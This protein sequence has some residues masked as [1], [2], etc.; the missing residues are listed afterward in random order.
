M[1][2]DQQLGLVKVA[3]ILVICVRVDTPNSTVQTTASTSEDA[4]M[5]DDGDDADD[6]GA[7][8][9]DETN[10]QDLAEL[11]VHVNAL[12][13]K[14]LSIL[15]AFG[16][17][18][19]VIALQGLASIS[20]R[21]QRKHLKNVHNRFFNTLFAGTPSIMEVDTDAQ[22]L[23]LTRALTEMKLRPLHWRSLTPYFLVDNARFE[24]HGDEEYFACSGYLKGASLSPNN[25]AY[26]TNIG[27]LEIARV[28][29]TADPVELNR[30]WAQL[31][32]ICEDRN[33][34]GDTLQWCK[35]VD[36]T[37]NEQTWPTEADYA[38]AAIS[39]K[40]APV[41][42][43]ASKV[44]GDTLQTDENAFMP[45]DFQVEGDDV[46]SDVADMDAEMS[47]AGKSVTTLAQTQ[48]DSIMGT[49]LK[50]LIN[51][52]P[53][54]LFEERQRLEDER[55]RINNEAEE[56]QDWP[57][58]VDVNWNIPARHRFAR[59]RGMRSFKSTPWNPDESLPLDYGRISRF[60]DFKRTRK[61][62][63]LEQ[64]MAKVH[65]GRYVTVYVRG[66]KAE[67]L[68]HPWFEAV[69]KQRAY[70]VLSGL[71]RHENRYSVV[72]FRMQHNT[73]SY[74]KP[75]KNKESLFLHVGFRTFRANPLWSDAKSGRKHRML[76]FFHPD[77]KW[78]VGSIYGPVCYPPMPVLAFKTP[79][80]GD[81]QP[82]L[83]AWGSVIDCEPN[84][85]TLKRVV[86]TGYPYKIHKRQAVIK[87]MFYNADDVKYFKPVHVYTKYGHQG[88]IKEA[89]GTHGVMKVQFSNGIQ[90]HDTICMDLWKRVFP[91][92]TTVQP[93]LVPRIQQMYT[94]VPHEHA[95]VEDMEE[96][97]DM[98][99]A[100][101]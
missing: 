95:N 36:T 1:D 88:H 29:T 66:I 65:P 3:D 60:D 78:A 92:W 97:A 12:G 59:Y 98:K 56:D 20:N 10:A 76:R 82:K 72:N 35:A 41:G 81:P 2:L 91:K 79:Q 39:G 100:D 54:Q 83:V 64:S 80:A 96:M 37:L 42:P 30:K 5:E 69:Q 68:N 19:V 55:R 33:D 101:E 67:E 46:A 58:E 18:S 86:I 84:R 13:H 62:V 4:M 6:D 9:E 7:L 57:D 75:I 51:L 89:I 94:C 22:V 38:A 15:T 32:T 48:V 87:F 73:L 17:P 43:D 16:V 26:I 45:P 44:F 34:K 53:E 8:G 49:D 77:E 25:L 23:A 90:A 71:R 63:F 11:G 28:E 31:P 40:D 99:A 27:T 85:M 61:M 52:S 93:S 70:M 24:K 74:N 14:F 21:K 47:E 50:E